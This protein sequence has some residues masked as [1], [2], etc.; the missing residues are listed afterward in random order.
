MDFPETLKDHRNNARY[1]EADNYIH[2]AKVPIASKSSFMFII[3]SSVLDL[4]KNSHSDQG[5]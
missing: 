1:S 3:M 5:C 4:K 2:V